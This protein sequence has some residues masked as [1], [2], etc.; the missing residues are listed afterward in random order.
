VSGF[1]SLELLSPFVRFRPKGTDELKISVGE[2]RV[3]LINLGL[4]L[5]SGCKLL[6]KI[7]IHPLN[8]THKFAWFAVAIWG[9]HG[10]S[11]ITSS[12]GTSPVPSQVGH[13]SPSGQAPNPMQVGHLMIL[14]T[15]MP[16]LIVYGDTGLFSFAQLQFADKR[17]KPRCCVLGSDFCAE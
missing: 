15:A 13:L 12:L 5:T 4:S 1:H 7:P 2:T 14:K 6:A 16:K 11:M 10:S 8:W 17:R 9:W 3:L